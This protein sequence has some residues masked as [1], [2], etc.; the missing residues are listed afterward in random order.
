ME[1][2]NDHKNAVVGV[3]VGVT[4]GLVTLRCHDPFVTTIVG[5][6]VRNW[7]DAEILVD[8]QAVVYAGWIY[9]FDSESNS[10]YD[11]SNNNNKGEQ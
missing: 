6:F 7:G 2:N 8:S 9:P 3:V 11:Q 5:C 10:V 1:I 4:D